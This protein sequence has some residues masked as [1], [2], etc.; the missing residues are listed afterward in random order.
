MR[1]RSLSNARPVGTLMRVIHLAAMAVF[2]RAA[3][4]ASG[5]IVPVALGGDTRI[6]ELM[7]DRADELILEAG[8]C[9]DFCVRGI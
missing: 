3:A 6:R 1:E 8:T 4:P 9:P 5:E 2:L 7:Y